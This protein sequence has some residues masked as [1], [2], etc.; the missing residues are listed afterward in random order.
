VLNPAASVRTASGKLSCL[1]ALQQARLPIPEFTTN[2]HTAQQWIF[3]GGVAYSRTV[4]NGHSAEGI[5]VERDPAAM[6]SAPLYTKGMDKRH[7]FRVHVFGG[8]VIDVTRKAF[9]PDVLPAD[10]NRDIMNHSTGTVFIRTGEA[11]RNIPQ[12]ILDDSIAAVAACGL[13]F[14]GVDIMTERNT[15]RHEILEINTAC[16]LEGTTLER[17]SRAIHQYVTNNGRVTPWDA[18][19]FERDHPETVAQTTTSPSANTESNN[20]SVIISGQTVSM[21]SVVR[22]VGN[23]SSLANG[24]DYNVERVADGRIY[25]M[26][27]NNEV[28]PYSAGNFHVTVATVTPQLV[29][30][31]PPE[32]LCVRVD[33]P[34]D[35]PERFGAVGDG[36]L[37]NPGGTVLMQN[38]VSSAISRGTRVTVTN[39]F[40]GT[41]TNNLILGIQLPNGTVSNYQ[42]SHF[43]EAQPLLTGNV[44]PTTAS[45][46]RANPRPVAVNAHNGT[47]LG[48]GSHVRLISAQGGH[49]LLVGAL[50]IVES[51]DVETGNV[52][53]R[54]H[55]ASATTR[56]RASRLDG[57]TPTS[58]Q[59]LITELEAAARSRNETFNVT[60]DGSVMR[61]AGSRRAAVMTALRQAAV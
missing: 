32:G 9:R 14:G 54:A 2:Q 33:V 40:R 22:Y 13:D 51:V 38:N 19:E 39:L 49:G 53:V 1:R 12:A 60:V 55:D 56:I 34:S 4:L 28:R 7:E 24:R 42:A 43:S 20:M 31:P 36:S 23:A 21:G 11:L 27:N 61:I 5:V 16:G 46:S 45:A 58:Y 26:N 10:R 3:D 52:T 48:R 50:A 47:Q 57:L 25:I 59:L 29:A 8:V 18:T 35:S 30:T 41:R 17:Y 37:I 15:G 44:T 6:T